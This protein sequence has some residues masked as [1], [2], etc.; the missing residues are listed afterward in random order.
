MFKLNISICNIYTMENKFWIRQHIQIG[1]I[2]EYQVLNLKRY[3]IHTPN[4]NCKS[5]YI[6]KK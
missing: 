1:G 4:K 5:V 6:S 3:F 2:I